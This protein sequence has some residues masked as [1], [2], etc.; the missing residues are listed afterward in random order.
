MSLMWTFMSRWASSVMICFWT[1]CVRLS[2]TFK[3]SLIVWASCFTSQFSWSRSW[4]SLQNLK[5]VNI[6][7]VLPARHSWKTQLIPRLHLHHVFS[8]RLSHQL[9]L[10]LLQYMGHFLSSWLLFERQSFKLVI[11]SNFRQLLWFLLRDCMELRAQVAP[12]HIL[13][14]MPHSNWPGALLSFL[15]LLRYPWAFPQVSRQPLLGVKPYL[16]IPCHNACKYQYP[17]VT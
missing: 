14:L 2:P 5:E 13:S 12:S 1:F 10:Q 3:F 9:S 16:K 8:T 6:Y 4:F 15:S 17:L 11:K 7:K